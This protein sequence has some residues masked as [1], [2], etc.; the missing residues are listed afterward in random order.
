MA[1]QIHEAMPG[2]IW[3]LRSLNIA[4]LATNETVI[5]NTN[6]GK[7]QLTYFLNNVVLGSEG[8]KS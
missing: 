5:R 3:P 4:Q 8:D 2:I 6:V 1:A 7:S